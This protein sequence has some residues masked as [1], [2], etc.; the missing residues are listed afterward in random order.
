M[1][2]KAEGQEIAA[3]EE[4]PQATN[5]VDLMELLQGSLDQT[6]GSREKGPAEPREKKTAARTV[7]KP[8]AKRKTTDKK[9]PPKA[10]R[11]SATTRG[12]GR[13]RSE[14]RH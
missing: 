1:R 9:A 8:E 10:A 14:L 13:G 5:V 3:E 6:Q 4:A 11:A 2:A 12:Q 7:R